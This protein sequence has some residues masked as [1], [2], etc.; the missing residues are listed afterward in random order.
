[1]HRH[2]RKPGK[3][4]M[5]AVLAAG[6]LSGCAV[7]GIVEPDVSSAR[8]RSVEQRAV[9]EDAVRQ[10]AATSR[11]LEEKVARQHLQLLEKDAEIRALNHKLEAAILEVVR[12]M[13]KLRG[14]SGRAEAASALA[15]TEIALKSMP[16]APAL[17]LRDADLVQARQLLKLASEEF[18]KQNYDGT[19]YLTSQ[20]KML[21]R[22]P[23]G[24]PVR[25]ADTV[26]PDGELALSPT[27]ELRAANRSNV[28]EGPG[29]SFKVL[30]VVERGTAL[31]GIAY[32]G[33]WVR[34]TTGDGRAG[35]MHYSL[36]DQR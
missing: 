25:G 15:E 22:T 13:A 6:L 20:V 34:V 8:P 1:M 32:S 9:S 35:W 16:P 18:K 7:A 26:R 23:S 28:R 5:V 10:Y 3:L 17:R 27:L 14:L 2:R 30:F 29:P 21:I 36:V 19:V 33:V 4:G 31:S 24:R 12:A 11:E